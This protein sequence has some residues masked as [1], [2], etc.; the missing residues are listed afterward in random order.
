VWPGYFQLNAGFVGLVPIMVYAGAISVVIIFAIMWSW[1]LRRIKHLFNQSTPT[2]M[3][4]GLCQCAAGRRWLG[5]AVW[6]TKWPHQS[7]PRFGIRVRKNGRAIAGAVCGG[8]LKWRPYCC[9]SRFWLQFFWRKGV[10][11]K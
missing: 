6:F 2:I 10:E 5:C 3:T 8:P 4:G 7:G 11:D 9:C 1:M